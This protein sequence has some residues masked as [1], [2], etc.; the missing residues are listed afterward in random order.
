M[1]LFLYSVY[2]YSIAIN[3]E[4]QYIA[5]VLIRSVVWSNNVAYIL[6]A[7]LSAKIKTNIDNLLS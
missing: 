5:N 4:E 3:S 2:A 7:L 1:T 6:V